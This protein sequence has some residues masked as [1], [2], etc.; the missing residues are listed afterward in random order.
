MR[1]FGIAVSLVVAVA[2]AAALAGWSATTRGGGIDFDAYLSGYKQ[3]PSV[4]TRGRGDLDADIGRSG[5]HYTLTYKNL[6]GSAAAPG[7][8]GA[9]IHFGQRF[10]NGGV[11]AFLCGG[12]GQPVGDKPPCPAHTGTVR[13]TIR[14]GDIVGPAGQGIE[15]G[16]FAEVVA[17]MKAELTYANVHTDKFPDGE[18]RGQLYVSD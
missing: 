7:T 6:E 8:L 2:A 4:S 11:I 15:P 14:P 12:G 18:I 13:G 16:A 10:A 3:V 1:K 9:H 17:A 5:I